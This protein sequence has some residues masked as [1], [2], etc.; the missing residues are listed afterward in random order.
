MNGPGG[1]NGERQSGLVS[2]EDMI[3]KEEAPAARPSTPSLILKPP[4]QMQQQQHYQSQ[5][6]QPLPQEERRFQQQSFTGH[7]QPQSSGT[8]NRNAS[9]SYNGAHPSSVQMNRHHHPNEPEEKPVLIEVK[10]LPKIRLSLM[11][12]P[13]EEDEDESSSEPKAI[14]KRKKKKSSRR[15]SKER[16]AKTAAG[17]SGIPNGTNQ[18]T[19]RP[20][21]R[22][23][24]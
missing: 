2:L 23:G 4:Q 6:Q 5:R 11:P 19:V 9:G 14:K 16:R 20:G 3:R 15:K 10:P 1:T 12:S 17:A 21:G 22:N 18:Q 7:Q 8:I 13:R 24:W